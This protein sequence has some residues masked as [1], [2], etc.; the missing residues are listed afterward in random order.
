MKVHF[1]ACFG[2]F[3]FVHLFIR[4]RMR[5]AFSVTTRLAFDATRTNKRTKR[6][7]AA[8]NQKTK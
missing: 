2:I 7:A 3:C 6:A 1:V 8:I 4:N 5:E